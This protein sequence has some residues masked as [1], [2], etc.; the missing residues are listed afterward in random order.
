MRPIAR[1]RILCHP[2]AIAVQ[3][4]WGS[5]ASSIGLVNSLSLAMHIPTLTA[6]VTYL[7]MLFLVGCWWHFPAGAAPHRS[8]W[9]AS[10]RGGPA[11]PQR[12]M[13]CA[14]AGQLS[15][16]TQPG[17]VDDGYIIAVS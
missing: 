8:P 11:P 5:S 2:V 6:R 13:V 9:F 3:H 17:M 10:S 12:A 14:R 1:R 4:G 15:L 7:T 16:G